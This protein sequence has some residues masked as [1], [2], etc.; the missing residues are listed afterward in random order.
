M[1]AGDRIGSLLLQ[2][3]TPVLVAPFA[4]VG[5]V[6]SDD[7]DSIHPGFNL[8]FDPDHLSACL[9]CPTGQSRNL[10]VEVGLLIV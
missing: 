7:R 9:S 10:A 1:V 8:G 4:G 3:L 6:D 5:G 2:R